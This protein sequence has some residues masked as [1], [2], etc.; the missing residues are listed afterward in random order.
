MAISPIAKGTSKVIASLPKTKPIQKLGNW[1]N[2]DFENALA[3]STIASIC[4]KDGVGCAMYV[5]QSTHNEKIPEKRRK[6]VS[7]LDLTNGILMIAS[8]I[9]MFFAM[10]KFNE[11]IFNAIFK[12]S[13]NENMFKHLKELIRVEQKAAGKV[14]D[15]TFKIRRDF[16]DIKNS[17]GLSVFKV[18]TELFAATIFG[19]RVIVPFIA[20]PLAKVVEKKW[21]E[22]N[23][24]AEKEKS[25]KS[26]PTMQG[27]TEPAEEKNDTPSSSVPASAPVSAVSNDTSSTNLLAKYRK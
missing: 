5:Y 12:K 18:V 27:K 8:Q 25:D 21:D 3:L 4:L 20:T 15:S 24:K 14:P 10:R 23:A 26:D 6:F 19:K 1:F 22:K 13:F 17:K 2:K 9:G 16:N 7:A 11:K